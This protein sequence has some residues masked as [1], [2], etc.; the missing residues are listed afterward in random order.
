M[1]GAEI[2]AKIEKNSE[3]IE[4]LMDPSAFAL[5]QA[6]VALNEE[7]AHLAEICPHE[8]VDGYCIYCHSAQK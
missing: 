6:I 1:T 4:G 5:N 3:L 8:Y 7:N 2:K